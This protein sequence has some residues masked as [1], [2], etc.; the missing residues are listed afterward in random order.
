[1]RHLDLRASELK[2]HRF[3][4]EGATSSLRAQLFPEVSKAAR[5]MRATTATESQVSA[6]THRADP[7]CASRRV[8]TATA[9]NAATAETPRAWVAASSEPVL[10]Q[11]SVIH[12][13][14]LSKEVPT[15]TRPRTRGPRMQATTPL[16]MSA[17]STATAAPVR[18]SFDSSLD[19]P[20][21]GSAEPL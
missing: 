11:I 5:P 16:V 4:R 20:P 17:D 14:A 19:P 1:M 9:A 13:A 21:N 8:K 15:S 6:V 3:G 10:R 7:G 12:N 2:G 18:E